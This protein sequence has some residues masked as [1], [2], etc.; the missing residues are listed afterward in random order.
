MASLTVNVKDAPYGAVGDG[1]TDDRAAIQAAVDFLV[2]N[3]GGGVLFF[4][5]RIYSNSTKEY[6]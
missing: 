2:L 3:G 1:V 5:N 6:L 4:P